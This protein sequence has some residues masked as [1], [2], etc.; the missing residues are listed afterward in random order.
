MT[1]R[2]R[3]EKWCERLDVALVETLTTEFEAVRAEARAEALEEALTAA[4]D[5]CSEGEGAAHLV[6]RAQFAH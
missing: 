5:E 4:E 6:A 2:E 1:P 3:A